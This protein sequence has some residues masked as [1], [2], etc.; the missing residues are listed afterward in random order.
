[1]VNRTV[2]HIFY[3]DF[4]RGRG[5]HKLSRD[6]GNLSGIEP[7][8]ISPLR[9]DHPDSNR[10]L[11]LC[12]VPKP[13]G[14]HQGAPFLTWKLFN[15]C[16]DHNIQLAVIHLA[17]KLNTLADQLSRATR[18]V[19]TEWVLNCP[20]FRAVTQKWGEPGIDL[21][22][23]R[24]NKQL[25]IYVSPFP[26]PQ[27]FDT[28]ALSRDWDILLF[29]YLSLHHPSFRWCC[30]MWSSPAI[31]SCSSPLSGLTSHGTPP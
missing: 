1:M 17:G 12:F 27:A 4:S 21:F 25:L 31:H 11:D 26:D 3:M 23:T 24:L 7:L 29:P 13:P 8:L 18:P 30:K 14:R 28:D 15:L 22:A 10:Q 6:D 20:V 9:S 2:L 5:K 19:T 16:M